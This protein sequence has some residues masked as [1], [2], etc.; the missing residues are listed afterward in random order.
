MKNRSLLLF[1]AVTSLVTLFVAVGIYAA[2]TVPDSIRMENKAYEKH[3][4]GIVEFHHKKHAEEY[5][6]EHPEFYKNG[7]G[8]CH[9]DENKKPLTELKAG[10]EVKGC[11]ACHSK[12]GY[13]TGK[14]A[15]G[16]KAK[17][18]REYHANAIHDNCRGCHKSYNK[19]MKLKSKDP[20]AAPTTCKNC[21]P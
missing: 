14:K 17:Q 11:M 8:E 15:K 18:K 16:L 3:T 5:A 7:C 10:D 20:G 1:A 2:A 9:H 12:P 21:H 4:K 19:K 13:I 6:K